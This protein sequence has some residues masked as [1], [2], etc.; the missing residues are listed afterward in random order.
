MIGIQLE[1]NEW[2]GIDDVGKGK[3]VI[4]KCPQMCSH[5]KGWNLIEGIDCSNF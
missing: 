2:N 4:E 5:W 3:S 1:I